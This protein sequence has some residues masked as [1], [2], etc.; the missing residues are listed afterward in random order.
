VE[1]WSEDSGN[2]GLAG[3]ELPSAEVLAAGQRVTAW[4][5][6]LRKAGLDGGLD[7]LRARAF[8]D[9]LLGMDSRPPAS[10]PDRTHGTG[11]HPSDSPAAGDPS[12]RSHPASGPQDGA[13]PAGTASYGNS[14]TRPPG[15]TPVLTGCIAAGGAGIGALAH[16]PVCASRP[17]RRRR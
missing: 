5:K 9:I 8:L 2:A 6:E 11:S 17:G 10:S 15:H 13:G 3:R 14:R 12:T 4:A 16:E 7:A 1:R